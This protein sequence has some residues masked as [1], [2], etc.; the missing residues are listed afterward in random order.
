VKVKEQ[1][2]RLTYIGRRL[3]VRRMMKMAKRTVIV[4][5]VVFV[6]SSGVYA[7]VLCNIPV[8][9]TTD[10]KAK[11]CLFGYE[12]LEIQADFTA[13]LHCAYQIDGIVSD[14][15]WDVFFDGGDTVPDNGEFHDIRIC[16]VIPTLELAEWVE[17]PPFNQMHIGTVR[18]TYDSPVGD[19]FIEARDDCYY[20]KIVMTEVKCQ[21][22]GLKPNKKDKDKDNKS[23]DNVNQV[24]FNN[25]VVLAEKW[26]EM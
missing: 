21:D 26:L 18:I 9:L 6:L 16:V 20:N 4:T 8:F 23:V 11:K 13:Q 5:A 22:L 17:G 1:T 24:D 3:P 25:F 7:D 14:T 15:N 10:G 19:H 2:I 12:D